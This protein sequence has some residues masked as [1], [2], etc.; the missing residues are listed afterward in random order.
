MRRILL[1]L[2]SLIAA[3]TVGA[4][5]HWFLRTPDS[6][7][8]SMKQTEPSRPSAGVQ[9]SHAVEPPAPPLSSRIDDTTSVNASNVLWIPG[10]PVQSPSKA[11]SPIPGLPAT[12]SAVVL[13]TRNAINVLP[14][15]AAGERFTLPLLHGDIANGVVTFV[16]RDTSGIVRV[17]ATVENHNGGSVSLSLA[18]SLLSGRVLLPDSRLAYTIEIDAAGR[19][20]LKENALS[21]IICDPFPRSA[22]MN[23]APLLATRS[24][25]EAPPI[26]SSR[27]SATA[28]LYLDFD[29]ETVTDPDWNNGNP[30]TALPSLLSN[31]QIT[32]VWKRVS[33]DYAPFNIDVTTDL[34][35]YT[36]APAGSRARC[37]ITPTAQWYDSG[38]AG[39]VAYRDSFARGGGDFTSTIPCWAFEYYFA[40]AAS[41][42]MIVS[43]E[44]GHTLGLKHDGRTSPAD[45]YYSGHNNWG[46]IMGAAYNASLLQWSKGEYANANN[47]EDDL[48]II[49][50][51][52]NGFGYVADDIGDSR[53]TATTASV[54]TTTLTASGL[55]S[56][57]DD[58]DYFSF[59]VP[60]CSLTLSAISP[61]PSPNLDIRIEI[62]DST[63]AIL[64]SA[65][66]YELYASAE[67][68]LTAGTYYIKIE[69]VGRGNPLTDGYSD[70]ASLGAYSLTGVIGAPQASPVITTHPTSHT[71]YE[72]EY[73]TSF[74]VSA[75]GTGTLRYQWTKDGTDLVASSHYSGVQSAN[76][77]I[78]SP[79]TSDAGAYRVRISNL[80]G[81][82]TSDPA[83]LTVSLPPPPTFSY[84]V[85]PTASGYVG[86]SFYLN[87][88][89]SGIG[90]ITYQWEKDGVTLTN[91]NGIT[92]ATASSL[93]ISTLALT[94]SGSYRLKATNA[95]G[96]V[97][98]APCVLTVV[99]P[100]LPVL[101][102]DLADYNIV[103]GLTMNYWQAYFTSPGVLTYQW[104]KDGQAI[105]GAT[106][107]YYNIPTAQSSHAGKYSLVAT[108]ATGSVSSREATL[109]VIAPK[110]PVFT[111]HPE[112]TRVYT[113]NNL[114][115]TAFA[116]GLPA[117]TYQWKLN[118]V[119]LSNNTG[120]T[121]TVSTTSAADAGTYTV[122][123][124]NA[125]GSVTSNSATVTVVARAD[126][127]PLSILPLSKSLGAG[128]VAYTLAVT[129]NKAWTASTS[130][131]WVSLSRTSGSMSGEIE[132]IVA[133]NASPSGR[134]TTVTIGGLPHTI[135]QA[136]SGTPIREAWG[137]G[138]IGENQ[139][140]TKQMDQSYPKRLLDDVKDV[141][142][143]SYTSYFLKNDGSLWGLGYGG[144][145][146]LGNSTH[147]TSTPIQITTN[148]TAVSAYGEH[149]LFLK[150]DQTLWGCGREMSG[151]LGNP[152]SYYS[153]V[154]TPRQIATDVTAMSIGDTHSVFV[155]SDGS[156]WG[157]GH[158]SSGRLG[159][160]NSAGLLSAPTQILASGVKTVACGSAHTLI[161]KTD[162]TLWGT[163]AND[164][165]QLGL[166]HSNTVY[167]PVQIATN[168]SQIQAFGINSA[169]ITSDDGALR[170]MGRNSNGLLGS[171]STYSVTSPYVI[172][173]DVKSAFLGNATLLYVKTDNVLYAQGDNYGGALGAGANT[174]FASATYI[175]APVSS[176]SSG[177]SHTL[178]VTTDG[179]VYGM[180]YNGYGQVGSSSPF[181]MVRPVHL[182]S[183]I[184][185]VSAGIGSSYLLTTDGA[186]Y[187]NTGAP[188][189]K[190]YTYASNPSGWQK[191]ATGI[192]EVA[193]TSGH[194]LALK[195][196]NS[197]YGAGTNNYYE[198][199]SG[200][201]NATTPAF[202]SLGVTAR[203]IAAGVQNSFVVKDDNTLWATGTNA[204]R[205]GNGSS[206]AFTKLT[207]ISTGIASVST[208]YAHTLFLKTD[209]TLLGSGDSYYYQSGGY[210]YGP[211]NYSSYVL[212]PNTL[213]TAVKAAA[214]GGYHTLYIK[215]DNTLWGFGAND[216]SQVG[217]AESS[218]IRTAVQIAT[219]VKL[220]AGGGR[221]TFY[222]KSSNELWSLGD[223]GSGQ[224]GRETEAVRNSTAGRVASNV[225]FVSAGDMHTLFIAN[226]D[227]RLDP[228]PGPTLTNFSPSALSHGSVVTI[229]GTNLG[230]TSQV[231]FNGVEAASFTVNSAT[232]VT[233]T[234][235]VS[236]ALAAG[237]L[238]LA[239]FDGIATSSGIFTVAWSPAV[240]TQPANQSVTNGRDIVF[241]SDASGNPVASYQWQVSTDNGTTW[242]NV[243]NGTAYN[244]ATTGKLT[245]IGATS[246]M[247][248]YRYRYSATNALGTATSNSFAL[249][250]TPV[251]FPRPVSLSL[252][253]AGSLYVADASAHTIQKITG[254]EVSLFAGSPGSTGESNGDGN[255]A[256]FNEPRGV[257]FNGSGFSVADTSNGLVRTITTTGSVAPLAGSSTHRTH[258]D[259]T[260]ANG[261]FA[262]PR[263][264]ARDSFGTTF[265]ADSTSHTIRKITS[266]GVVTTIAGSP[267]LHGTAD[268]DGTTARF[269]EPSDIA[270][271]VSGNLYVADTAN[272]TIR[273]I[274]FTPAVS[275]STLAGLPETPGDFDGTGYDA[276][277]R[278]PAG[279]TADNVGNV[280]VADTGNALI[281][282]ITTA[283]VVTTIAGVSGIEG[284]RDGAARDA[285]FRQPTDVARA[286]DGTLYIA[287]AGNA[288]IRKF[289]PDSTVQTINPTQPSTPGTNP[290]TGGG[291]SPSTPPAAGGGGGGGGS[292]SVWFLNALVLVTGLR[293]YRRRIR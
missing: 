189:T 6:R 38:N 3:V 87:N 157:I 291:G 132:I 267:G 130:A 137:M 152:A 21:S 17:A 281:R 80:G 213:A 285:W 266:S 141:A 272:H 209:G 268:G 259:G 195:A 216:S 179:T 205:F 49:G 142:S 94:H 58:V 104:Y 168:V 111:R 34:S 247:N 18:G 122:T 99:M 238:K 191:I 177:G 107:G 218:N 10:D 280:Y 19:T 200:P 269:N 236:N 161:L 27:P 37:I 9:A 106:N 207:Q 258:Q 101:N 287:D 59:T 197:V 125:A 33:E 54:N 65:N 36:S 171:Q 14:S 71:A 35:R 251:Q 41:T 79:V 46:P 194:V 15:L 24:P 288:A 8:A 187:A 199:P 193:S 273:K 72:G 55:I 113:G 64:I 196:D 215:A 139:L 186:L 160:G 45:A 173:T 169:Y 230:G 250:V 270:I 244:G 175:A 120:E 11:A 231:V 96:S 20:L 43:H 206:T 67:V 278:S 30:I 32:E 174:R 214:A 47:V 50:V 85:N 25:E 252:D 145:G 103:Q 110:A 208:G 66:P 172:T 290:G 155:K 292:P 86:A 29:G 60:A 70:Y 13:D 240:I 164:Y 246:A 232:Q 198:L 16:Q 279:L 75:T 81:S 243:T 212:T 158:N 53:A 114:V 74:S 77:S 119:V 289:T 293:E 83:T 182:A 190:L 121:Y 63:G 274:T 23:A 131:R 138:A 134:T 140:G 147:S 117:P 228:P 162:G 126:A 127:G 261:W 93:S 143:S 276:A 148:V 48:A 92:G 82:V 68:G 256:R 227:I 249:T 234:V 265:V 136:G 229:T 165:G 149:V 73:Q 154:T 176:V 163:G 286:S 51:A 275:V 201:T 118:G 123:A 108:N 100:P 98:S 109:T 5:I 135:T 255:V 254:S 242:A 271:D 221:S 151:E 185:T 192:D 105:A 112:D 178:F 170:G 211:P 277:F 222:T 223:N 235:P 2:L 284:M 146:Q 181:K 167:S 28:V 116:S 153:S 84:Y 257:S 260:G 88:Y 44:L 202:L 204:G 61:S 91:G 56:T 42:A 156:L 219:D 226:G 150:A 97:Y 245:V 115:L 166:G 57:T 237:P 62:Q 76:L 264:V 128:R 241:G 217:A 224:L 78:Y 95:G 253:T 262:A 239:T 7:P 102:T 282:K 225:V 40:N 184:E 203:Q 22:V 133:P 233:A 31:S 220:F 39:G 283:G 248:D 89:A 69:G 188:G 263:G 144:Y 12:S 210:V 90:T 129:S 52:T 159:L 1:R 124:T 183:Q 4:S 180:G 26:H